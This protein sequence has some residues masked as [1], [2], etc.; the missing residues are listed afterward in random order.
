MN[1]LLEQALKYEQE[2]N[3]DKSEQL[4]LKALAEYSNDKDVLC[5]VGI[6]KFKKGDYVN[7]LDLFVQSYSHPNQ[8]ENTKADLLNH[9]LV[10]YYQPHLE[11]FKEIYENNVRALL[12]YKYSHILSFIDFE[13]LSYLCI[14][15]NESEYYIWDKKMKMFK[16]RIVME[17]TGMHYPDVFMDYCVIATNIFQ[18][19]HLNSLAEQTRNPAW[20]NN[21]KVP[22][23]LVWQDSDKMQQF[24]QLVDYEIIISLNRFV[25]FS[26]FSVKSGIR[27]FLED[28]QAVLFNYACGDLQYLEQIQE[29]LSHVQAKRQQ[30]THR[31]TQI[32]NQMAQKYNREYYIEIFSGGYDKIRILFYT[33]RFTQVVQYGTRDFMVACQNLGIQCD[34]VIERSDIHRA[35]EDELAS[36]IAEFKPNVI[37][38]INFFKSDF[39]IIPSNIMFITWLQDPVLQITSR[40]H[41]QQFGWNDFAL[42]YTHIWREKMIGAGYDQQRITHQTIP[43]DDK[44][45]YTR[46]M[47]AKEKEFYTAEVAFAGNYYRPEKY[48]ADFITDHTTNITDIEEKNSMINLL[49]SA[50]EVLRSKIASDELVYR[51]EQ[52]ETVINELATKLDVKI[53]V[54]IVKQ[55]AYEYFEKLCYTLYRKIYI[56][57]IIDAGFNVKLWGVNWDTDPDLKGN[58][59]GV[60]PHGEELAKMYS[61]TKIVPA[62]FYMYTAHFRSWEATSCG[63]LCMARY[64]PPDFDL[65]NI[66]DYFTEDEHF[67]FYHNKQDLIDKIKY[68]LDNEEERKGIVENGKQKVLENITYSSA[69]RKCLNLIKEN[70]LNQ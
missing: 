15:R 70:V 42:T 30:D 39:K 6:F 36:K 57:A 20:I 43:I 10:A 22:I 58:A 27:D 63:A 38:R 52:C 54:G 55:I 12:A 16:E 67:V 34:K 7:A 19:T 17:Q 14:P 64:V 13:D 45:F 23:Y 9:I 41:A 33:S 28:H 56:K 18:S 11:K 3:F 32:I 31:N 37:F 46:D 51:K 24:L 40:E 65:L 68:Y 5:C 61:C 50:Y 44:I 53:E 60:I 47:T 69:V 62:S 29:I 35:G 4:Y 21:V 59:M 48:L 25:I 26:D 1:K 2:N 66:R 49:L 8:T